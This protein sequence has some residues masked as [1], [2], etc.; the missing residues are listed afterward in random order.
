MVPGGGTAENLK[1]AT[2]VQRGSGRVRMVRGNPIDGTRMREGDQ[3]NSIWRGSLKK[4]SNYGSQKMVHET[5]RNL[6]KENEGFGKRE[7]W[8]VGRNKKASEN[9][10]A[11]EE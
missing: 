11:R 6:K 9:P 4:G 7:P 8:K 2:P 5:G 10:I 3:R 1:P